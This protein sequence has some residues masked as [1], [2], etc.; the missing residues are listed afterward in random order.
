MRTKTGR[1]SWGPA[2]ANESFPCVG[3]R[4]VMDESRV[5][6]AQQRELVQRL[7]LERVPEVR[8]F[9]AATLP[10][11]ALVD[12][13]VADAFKAITGDAAY[14]DPKQSFTDWIRPHV[15]RAVVEIGRQSERSSQPFSADVLDVL[16]ASRPEAGHVAAV[17]RF[18]QECVEELAPQA[19]R[20]VE[21]R[22]RK[23]LKPREVAK[24]M[25]WT[26]PSVHVALSRARAAVRKCVDNKLAAAGG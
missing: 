24:L 25:G 4:C 21:L 11:L 10:D 17:R 5:T 14:Y 15:R 13:V 20:I 2:A 12:D 1:P 3:G 22:Y 9:V 19:R 23:A 6:P 26:N 18:L 8:R 16:A 7:F